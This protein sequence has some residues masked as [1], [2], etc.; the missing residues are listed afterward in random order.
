ML[1]SFYDETYNVEGKQTSYLGT[2]EDGVGVL[3]IHNSF[4][5]QIGYFGTGE[6]GGGFLK[7]S[8]KDGL[9]TTYLGEG[10]DSRGGHLQTYNKNSQLT[11]YIGTSRDQAGS[12]E[13]N[14]DY[15]IT[16][17]S[18]TA[19]YDNDNYRGDGTL[20][21]Y[22]RQGEFGLLMDGKSN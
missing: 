13:I 8:N 20:I 12:L 3:G 6:Q 21:L 17:G 7:T 19:A 5:K 11:S 10:K 2:A 1:W 18:L 14:N 9:M 15:G 16:V 22:N 4:G